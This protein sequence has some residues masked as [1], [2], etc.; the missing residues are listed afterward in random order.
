[1]R[2][3]VLVL[4]L[5]FGGPAAACSCGSDETWLSYMEKENRVLTGTVFHGR[6]K[7]STSPTEIEV[8][9]LEPLTGDIRAATTTVLRAAN[10]GDSCDYSF[11]PG[12]W[13]AVFFP[14]ESGRLH[15]CG[16]TKSANPETLARLRELAKQP[17]IPGLPRFQL[18]SAPWA[19]IVLGLLGASLI[20]A[21][22]LFARRI[23]RGSPD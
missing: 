23:P 18:A 4:V 14:D 21:G 16:G 10:R 1:M 11:P 3:L 2:V 5:L 13:S 6:V 17:Q 8:E 12:D 22:A 9:V 15:M 7:R 19:Q 20:G